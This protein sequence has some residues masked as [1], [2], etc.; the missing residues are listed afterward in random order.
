MSSSS[1]DL[2]VNLSWVIVYAAYVISN[3][4]DTLALALS[5]SLRACSGGRRAIF[6]LA[7]ALE[8]SDRADFLLA[9]AFHATVSCAN[10]VRGQESICQ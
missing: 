5:A 6:S 2:E 4:L 3:A 10:N 1:L 8:A 7:R 9:S